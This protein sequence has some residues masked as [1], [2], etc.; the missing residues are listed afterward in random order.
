MGILKARQACTDA[1][2]H[3]KRQEQQEGALHIVR[4]CARLGPGKG[5]HAIGESRKPGVRTLDPQPTGSEN[6]QQRR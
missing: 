6:Q 3:V 5:G 2:E 1:Q 4:T